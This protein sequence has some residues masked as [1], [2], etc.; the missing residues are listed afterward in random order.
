MIDDNYDICKKLSENNIK[1]LYFRDKNM[2][3]LKESDYLKEV[4]NW[5]NIYTYINKLTD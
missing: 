1:T 2:K 4:N 5:A 3:K